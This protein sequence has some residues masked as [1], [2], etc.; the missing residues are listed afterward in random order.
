[1]PYAQEKVNNAIATPHKWDGPS[2]GPEAVLEKSIIFV[3]S[4][5]RN[6]GVYGV[7]RGMS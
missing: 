2:D 4:D 6:G 1:M 3:A 5:L 7:A